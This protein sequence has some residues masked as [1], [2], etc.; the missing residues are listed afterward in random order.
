MLPAVRPGAAGGLRPGEGKAWVGEVRGG[1]FWCTSADPSLAALM[2]S[3]GS[4]VLNGNWAVSPPG[5]YEA[6]GTRV[7]YTRATGLEETLHAAGP[8][9][10][11]LLLQV[12]AGPSGEGRAREAGE[13]IW[14]AGDRGS[15]GR[16]WIRDGQSGEARVE[17]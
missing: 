5:T 16:G 15:E 10:Q 12:W 3:D 17:N 6:A 1:W 14:E 11:D 8:T 13:M 7:V 2:V 9:S 4:Y